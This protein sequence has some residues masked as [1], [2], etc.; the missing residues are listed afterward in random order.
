MDYGFITII[1]F[2]LMAVAII[3]AVTLGSQLKQYSRYTFDFT[4]KTLICLM[5][6]CIGYLLG[7][8]F[9]TFEVVPYGYKAL[10]GNP[11]QL[12]LGECAPECEDFNDN[13]GG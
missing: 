10:T 12:N 13:I 9:P 1:V 11:M 8:A 3:V 2:G 6:L 7:N 5:L 4:R